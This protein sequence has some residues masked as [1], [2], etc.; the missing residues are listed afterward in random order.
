LQ[1]EWKQKRE[2]EKAA[3]EAEVEARMQKWLADAA[4]KKASEG[5]Q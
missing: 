4:K 5:G 2:A 1:E 3:R